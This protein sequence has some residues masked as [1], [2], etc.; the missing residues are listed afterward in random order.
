MKN[1]L[2]K[3][4]ESSPEEIDKLVEGVQ[5]DVDEPFSEED[6]PEPK[7]MEESDG[8][9]LDDKEITKELD[10]GSD[11]DVSEASLSEDEL[12][13]IY[14]E[15]VSEVIRESKAKIAAKYKSKREQ[16]KRFKKKKLAEKKG[17]KDDKL[18]KKGKLDSKLNGKLAKGSSKDECDGFKETATLES[19]L[20][21]LLNF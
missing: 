1:V 3:I 12:M 9:D 5:F 15:C 8:N 13:S 20:N 6:V 10:S 2:D 21:D 11:D 18:G 4:L 19:E 17:L 7:P 16:V 14:S